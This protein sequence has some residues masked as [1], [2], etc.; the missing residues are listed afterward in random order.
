M[1]ASMVG[2]WSLHE[3]EHH[4]FCYVVVYYKAFDILLIENHD[5]GNVAESMFVCNGSCNKEI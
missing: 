2:M 4:N 3:Q 5:S 1:H